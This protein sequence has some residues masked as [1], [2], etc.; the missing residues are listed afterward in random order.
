MLGFSLA[1]KSGR[2]IVHT[3]DK[4]IRLAG[5]Q[6]RKNGL[7]RLKLRPNAGWQMWADA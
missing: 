1:D 4:N 5:F 3:D 2:G 6:E 7:R